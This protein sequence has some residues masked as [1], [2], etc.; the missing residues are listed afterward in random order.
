MANVNIGGVYFDIR[1]DTKKLRQDLDKAQRKLK[2]TATSMNK[3]FTKMRQG[4]TRAATVMGVGMVASAGLLGRKMISLGRDFESSMKTVQ[5]WSGASGKEL[6]EL[7]DIAKKM[8]AT[9][10][11]TAKQSA[12]ALQFLA[13]AGLDT[14]QSI[15]ALPQALDLATAGQVDLATATDITTDVMTA[16]GMEVEDLNRVNDAFIVTS[17]SS[18]TNVS[19][20]GQS[21]KMVA[22]TAKLFGYSVEQTAALLGTLANAGVKAEMAGSGLNMAF[23]K[24]AKAAKMLGVDAMT[25]LTEILRKMKEEQWNATKI[26]EAF[27]AR[28][29]KTVAILMDGMGTYDE[30]NQKIKE[31]AGAT[32]ELAAVIRDSLDVDIKT[33]NS[34]IEDVLLEAFFAMKDE[35]REIIQATTDWVRANKTG[36]V[37]SI[38]A[39]AEV[40]KVAIIPLQKWAELW[41]TIGTLS[42]ADLDISVN[43]PVDEIYDLG[44]GVG[45][46]AVNTDTLTNAVNDLNAA[47]KESMSMITPV[48]DS[49]KK[50]IGTYKTLTKEIGNQ[51]DEV[52]GA[53]KASIKWASTTTFGLQGVD[54]SIKNTTREWKK[55][56]KEVGIGQTVALEWATSTTYGTQEVD[57][58]LKNHIK[59]WE[60]YNEKVEES[61]NA[62]VDSF[63]DSWRDG[64]RTTVSLFM[65]GE[66]TKVNIQKLTGDVLANTA[67]SISNKMFDKAI[68]GIIDMIGVSIGQGAAGSGGW[69]AVAGGWPGAA[70]NIGA[71]L[72]AGVGS[73]VAGKEMANQFRAE[74]GWL[75]MH[76][77]GGWINEGSG[78]RDDVL[79]GVTQGAR[80][81]G[82]GGEYVVNKNAANKHSGLLEAINRGYAGGG[83]LKGDLGSSIGNLDKPESGLGWKNMADML[84]MG[85]GGSFLHGCY[86]G[87]AVLTGA[88]EAG[89]FAGTSIPSMFT[90]KMLSDQFHSKGGMIDVGHFNIFKPWESDPI[91]KE[92][93]R[94]EDKLYDFLPGDLQKLIPRGPLAQFELMT[95][96]EAAWKMILEMI[97]TPL[98]QV[99]KDLVEPKKYYSNPIDTVGDILKGAEDM[100]ETFTGI[101]LPDIFGS[102]GVAR[103]PQSGY[104]ATLHG[105]E[106]VV[107]LPDGQTIPVEI[108]GGGQSQPVY[109]T[110]ELDGEKMASFIYDQTKAGNPVVHERGITRI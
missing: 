28:Q 26:G 73:M 45:E 75:G 30:L 94:W 62:V 104:N 41:Q 56:N 2:G 6:Q 63:V 16:F 95:D 98:E 40:V 60:A 10:E 14:K 106:A 87:G 29:V 78:Q 22:P 51:T 55:Y 25:P 27:G 18:N 20:L 37:S 90:G 82:M 50:N 9:T 83:E 53:G 101:D 79:L 93:K 64:I 74:G 4:A 92:V 36:L 84:A 85:I 49:H 13:A 61:T 86:K 66:E 54:E 81:W 7:T 102:G 19:M 23:L 110:I 68:D 108:K 72:A 39:I 15:A 69:G 57:E 11:W 91:Y 3:N 35:I 80:H 70:L 33:L 47:F 12:D 103:G 105:T 1:G 77:G 42:S 107:P 52:D 88:I 58:N 65:A 67:G 48:Y 43:I 89:L 59:N 34:T 100:F 76:P 97:R 17:S 46:T 109:I 96:P 99:A 71:F 24:S 44:L 8:G 21:F 31:N 38:E 32:Q 5:A